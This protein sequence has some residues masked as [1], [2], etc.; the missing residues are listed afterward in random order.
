MA[1]ALTR[2]QKLDYLFKLHH[3]IRSMRFCAG[4]AKTVADVDPMKAMDF[5]YQ[6]AQHALYARHYINV[7]RGTPCT[8]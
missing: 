6:Y 1:S 2:V 3:R 8:F 4:L 7:L 5:D